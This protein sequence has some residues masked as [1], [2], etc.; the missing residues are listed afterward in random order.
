MS[1][2]QLGEFALAKQPLPAT[3]YAVPREGVVEYKYFSVKTDF[4]E[5]RWIKSFEIEPGAVRVTTVACQQLRQPEIPVFTSEPVGQLFQSVAGYGLC[6]SVDCDA[7]RQ[8]VEERRFQQLLAVH[9]LTGRDSTQK[10]PF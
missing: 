3:G 1:G 7:S 4:P 10:F 8:P 5:D 9:A 6:L 2:C